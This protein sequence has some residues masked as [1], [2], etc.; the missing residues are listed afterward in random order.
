M[1]AK[2][3]EGGG[4][5]A[6]ITTMIGLGPGPAGG[7]WVNVEHTLTIKDIGGLH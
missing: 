5:V 4:E 7:R 2:K 1:I 6:K 3:E